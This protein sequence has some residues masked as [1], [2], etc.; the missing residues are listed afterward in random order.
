MR[1]VQEIMSNRVLWVGVLCWFAAQFM[2]IILTAVIERRWDF[3]RLLFGHGGMPSSHSAMVCGMATAVG[4]ARGFY[5]VEFAV[6]TLMAFIVMT[7][8]TGVRRAAGKQAAVLNKIVQDL[9]EAGEWPST[10]KLKEMLGHTPF[11]V[12]IGALLG[13]LVALLFM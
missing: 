4:I 9:I 1:Y 13:V 12:I 8:A 6:C 7:D 11:Q 10:E 3:S 5:S 2:K